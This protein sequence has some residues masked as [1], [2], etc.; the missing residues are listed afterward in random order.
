MMAGRW[1]DALKNRDGRWTDDDEYFKNEG[2]TDDGCLG[3]KQKQCLDF[4]ISNC[5]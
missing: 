3:R 2:R 4:T 5:G 1:T